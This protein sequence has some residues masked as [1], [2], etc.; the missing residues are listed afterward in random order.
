MYDW[1]GLGNQSRLVLLRRG[2]LLNNQ[3][4]GFTLRFAGLLG[5]TPSNTSNTRTG[6]TVRGKL[7][8]LRIHRRWGLRLH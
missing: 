8:R 5:G 3:D 7:K 6:L 1:V 2:A 4:F